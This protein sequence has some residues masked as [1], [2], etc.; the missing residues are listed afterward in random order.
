[1]NPAGHTGQCD[2]LGS[3]PT[4]RTT[5]RRLPERGRYDRATIDAILDAGFVCH[6][7]MVIHDSPVV[8]PTLYARRDD[9]VLVH[10][11][12]AARSL[13]HL[14]GGAEVCVTVT[15][16]D[17]LVLARSA[18]HHSANYRS[19]MLYGVPRRIE[20]LAERREA[21]EY[22]TDHLVPGRL[23]HLRPITEQ[24]VRAT[25]VLEVPIEEASAKVR[26]GPPE[27]D[28]DD[29]VLPIWAGVVPLRLAAADPVPD[30]RNLAGLQPPDHVRGWKRT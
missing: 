14:Q 15:L 10:G 4:E 25:T 8:V 3:M 1:M 23:P 28:E 7:G 17:G 29:Y 6:L 9:H 2:T 30:P 11:S 13:R 27:D 18:F 21:L 22:L 12:P 5:L 24:E 20:D 19:V 26:S 16:L